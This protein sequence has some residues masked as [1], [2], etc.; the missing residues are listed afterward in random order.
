MI[1]CFQSAVLKEDYK[2]DVTMNNGN[3][4]IL[5]MAHQLET[6]QFCP[7]KDKAVW[8]SVEIQDTCLRWIGNSTVEL[9]IDRLLGLFRAGMKY[10]QDAAIDKVT[11]DQNWRLHLQLDNGN[12]LE[13]DMSQLLQ[14]SLFAPLSIKGLWKTMQVKEHSLLWQDSNIQLE[15]PVTTILKYFA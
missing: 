8:K 2:L 7:L 1:I 10:G 15:I 9:S 3:R 11:S 6:V 5:D 14:C 4:L 13:I 12:Q